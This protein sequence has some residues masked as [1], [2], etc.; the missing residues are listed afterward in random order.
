MRQLAEPHQGIQ[1]AE[2]GQM[3]RRQ[4]ERR[5]IRHRRRQGR[6]DARDTI[7]GQEQGPQPWREGKVVERGD[8]IVGEIDGILVLS[9]P[10]SRGIPPS[11][12][13]SSLIDTHT[14][15]HCFLRP[16]PPPFCSKVGHEK[17][18]G[19]KGGKMKHTY[20]G[21]TQVLNGGDLV[22]CMH[23]IPPPV[24][25]AAKLKNIK[26]QRNTQTTR[27]FSFPPAQE[28]YSGLLFKI[29]LP[30]SPLQLKFL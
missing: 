18:V 29:S 4:D 20:F 23:V 7:P 28:M 26:L 2:F 15:T 10:S 3:I 27:F 21:N 5:Q 19:E 12:Q 30:P 22:T 6:L 25:F 16:S 9:F 14:H 8:I 17:K 24:S 11:S 1:I 13:F